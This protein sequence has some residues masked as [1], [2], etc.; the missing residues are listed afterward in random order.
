MQ[1]GEFLYCNFM[2]LPSICRI[3]LVLTLAGAVLASAGENTNSGEKTDA[4]AD[5]ATQAIG[6]T[7]EIS[8]EHIFNVI[9]LVLPHNSLRNS[10][11]LHNWPFFA[12]AA[13]A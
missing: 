8:Q 10:K 5:S 2:L 12:V 7:T 1:A 13:P 6:D 4:K 3:V 9:G 11:T